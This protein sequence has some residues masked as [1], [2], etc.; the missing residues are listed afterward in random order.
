MRIVSGKFKGKK[1]IQPRDKSTRPLKDLTKESIFNLI[2]HSKIINLE[3]ENLIV[4]DL[5]AGSG[6][7]GL[8]CLSR[9]VKHVTFIEN[10][11]PAMEVLK[12]NI[13]SLNHDNNFELLEMDIFNEKIYKSFNK[14]YDLIFLDPPYL[15]KKIN[16]LLSIIHKFKL[17]NKKGIGIIHR[18]NKKNE[19]LSNNFKI[20]DQRIYG[21]SKI[22][23]FR[24]K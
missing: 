21:I 13:N 24:L 22:L 7:F 23:F 15:E 19:S 16:K 3:I 12:K 6:S 8:E 20:I 2:L 10:H 9:N 4:L 14:T 17:L 5:F 1:L 18:N 11:K